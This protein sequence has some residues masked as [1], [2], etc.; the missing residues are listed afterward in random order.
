EAAT[1]VRVQLLADE[2]S[3]FL[4]DAVALGQRLDLLLQLHGH[5][6]IDRWKEMAK[7]G[8]W[9]ALV[10]E[11]LERHYDP[12]Y[13]RAI[14]SHYPRLAQA[15]KIEIASYDEQAYASAARALLTAADL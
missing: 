14:V 6:V 11:L 4:A 12:A 10:T 2:Y 5:T 13:T 3:H 15:Q 7:Q 1:S 8:H 9:D